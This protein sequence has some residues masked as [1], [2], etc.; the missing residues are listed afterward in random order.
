MLIAFAILFAILVG[1]AHLAYWVVLL[2]GG[3]NILNSLQRRG[4]KPCPGVGYT[5]P[6]AKDLEL[7]TNGHTVLFNR[8]MAQK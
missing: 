2:I 4:E 7:E 6:T 1:L 3:L 8:L 5:R